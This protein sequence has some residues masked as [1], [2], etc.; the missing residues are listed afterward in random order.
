ML[1]CP[2]ESMGSAKQDIMQK[3]MLQ[4]VHSGSTAEVSNMMNSDCHFN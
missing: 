3:V 1:L 2:M 4:F